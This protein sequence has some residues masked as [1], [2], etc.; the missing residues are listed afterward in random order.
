[1]LS[2]EEIENI[3]CNAD[4]AEGKDKQVEQVWVNVSFLDHITAER[5]KYKDKADQLE[6]REQKLIEK[7]E[8]DK[9]E[10]TEELK[11]DTTKREARIQLNLIDK[12]LEIL[13]KE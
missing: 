1:M 10:L 13:K 4:F 3:I 9:K 8:E 5:N 2:K 11:Y 6:S 12:Y 7:L